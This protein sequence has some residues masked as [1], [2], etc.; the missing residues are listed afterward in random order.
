MPLKSVNDPFRESKTKL[1]K[2]MTK[3]HKSNGATVLNRKNKYTKLVG[4]EIE[5][6]RCIINK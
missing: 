3:N 2:G 5:G 4:L 1:T 6:Q